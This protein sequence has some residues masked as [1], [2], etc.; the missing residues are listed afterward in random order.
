VILSKLYHVGVSA[1][2]A[3]QHSQQFLVAQRS[4]AFAQELLA[5]S[6]G[7]RD[8]VNRLAH[9]LMQLRTDAFG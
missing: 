5:R 9:D 7:F 1:A 6:V 3:Q 4:R 2:F 8:F